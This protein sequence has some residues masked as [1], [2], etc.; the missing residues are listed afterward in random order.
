MSRPQLAPFAQ[1]LFYLGTGLWP[2]LHFRSFEKVT[3]PKVDGWLARTVGG[4]IAAVGAALVVGSFE[5]RPSR[6]L[7][8]LGV[9]SALALGA[10]DVIYA[11]RGRISKVYLGDA[12]AEAGAVAGWVISNRGL[13]KR[14]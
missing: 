6:S 1:G 5:E 3:G 12:A 2:I 8:L 7:A 9:G 11:S 4:L 13:L 10:A 14:N